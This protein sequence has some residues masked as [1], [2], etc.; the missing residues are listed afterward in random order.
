MFFKEIDSV[1]TE[2]AVMGRK[3]DNLER[4][5]EAANRKIKELT[6]RVKALEERLDTQDGITATTLN[7][8]FPLTQKGLENF[9]SIYTT[10]LYSELNA[11][12]VRH[13]RR[14]AEKVLKRNYEVGLILSRVGADIPVVALIDILKSKSVEDRLEE[15]I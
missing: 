2:I 6:G 10:V 15:I 7:H 1:Q 4:E 8:L 9:A 12:E 14:L 13:F 3:V 5:N 11:V